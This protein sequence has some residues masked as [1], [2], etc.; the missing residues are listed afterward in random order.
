MD[1]F[2]IGVIGTLIALV[3][4]GNAIRTMRGQAKGR[5]LMMMYMIMA[6]MFI[7]VIW[8]IILKLMPAS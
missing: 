8:F 1:P 3:I 5:G 6:M 4:I 7:G 2:W